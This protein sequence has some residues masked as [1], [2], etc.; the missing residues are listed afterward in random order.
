MKPHHLLNLSG[1][2]LALAL[3]LA[4]AGC[5]RD[6]S[7]GAVDTN[8]VSVINLGPEDIGV[9][10]ARSQPTGIFVYG[11]INPAVRVDIKAQVPGQI[12]TVLVNRGE[13]VKAGQVLA[14]FNDKAMLARMTA[15]R[16]ALSVAERDQNATEILFK[17]G[18]VSERVNANAGVNV[19]SAKAQ[20]AQ[21]QENIDNANVDSPINGVVVERLVSSGETAMPGQKLF[22]VIDSSTLEMVSTFLPSDFPLIRP[23]MQ[24][25]LKFDSLNDTTL[26]GEVVRIDPIADLQTGRITVDIRVKNDGLEIVP[27]IFGTGTIVTNA[28]T[29][30][31]ILRIPS[32]AVRSDGEGNHVMMLDGERIVR[33]GIHLDESDK[34]DGLVRVVDGLPE[35]SRYLLNP[36]KESVEGHPFKILNPGQPNGVVLQTENKRPRSV[37]SGGP[38]E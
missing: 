6:R 38:K 27:G 2:S 11:T 25:I 34:G 37:K 1:R 15:A 16:A 35:G 10:E 3:M 4:A 26:S 23:G 14:R 28:N 9:A 18:A 22:S 21:A 31:K 33:R 32:T 29:M 19:D 13:R 36:G 12:E 7:P 5:G 20:L 17:A 24:A 30:G 8:S